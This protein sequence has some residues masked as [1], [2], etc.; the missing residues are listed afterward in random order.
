MWK[1][2][3]VCE[4]AQFKQ[5]N[6]EK[7]REESKNKSVQSKENEM[8]RKE[9]MPKQWVLKICHVLLLNESVNSINNVNLLKI[10]NENME[11]KERPIEIMF[12]S[13][14]YVQI[15]IKDVPKA[16]CGR[17]NMRSF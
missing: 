4:S 7:K 17:C 13:I 14:F 15:W 2:L 5:I 8:K 10:N 12:Q 6:R 9:N 1:W 16:Y 11:K 3:C